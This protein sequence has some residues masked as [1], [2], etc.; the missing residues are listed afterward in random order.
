MSKGSSLHYVVLDTQSK[1]IGYSWHFSND[2]CTPVLL[3][4]I[5]STK[6]LQHYTN[7]D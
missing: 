1:N 4:L 7:T 5:L 6:H 2:K 3:I